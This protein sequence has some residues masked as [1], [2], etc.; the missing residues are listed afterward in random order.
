[1][2]QT[3]LNCY[4]RYLKGENNA[5]EEFVC[6]YSDSLI[7]YAYC[8]VQDAALAEDV[9]EETIATL[10]FHRKHFHDENHMQAYL[11]RVARNKSI[12]HLRKRKREVALS[13]VEDVLYGND[14]ESQVIR[15]SLNQQIFTCMQ[16]LPAQYKEVLYLTYFEDFTYEEVCRLMK[17]SK[18]QVYNLLSRAR[19]ALKEIF[20]KE[21]LS[22]EDL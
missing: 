4:M 8:Y 13:D 7:R 2:S 21:G 16:K 22:Y 11:Y 9:M 1:M 18:K 15:D 19:N 10:I 20:M 6:T 5:L 12:D 3:G 14:V 17:K